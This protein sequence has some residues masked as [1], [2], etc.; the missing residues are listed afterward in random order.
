MPASLEGMPHHS[1]QEAARPDAA[2]SLQTLLLQAEPVCWEQ[3]WLRR[4]CWVSMIRY[5]CCL[6]PQVLQL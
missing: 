5:P 2:V 6:S 3:V 1:V 4:V